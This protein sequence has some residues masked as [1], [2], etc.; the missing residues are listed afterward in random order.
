MSD[1][2]KQNI[3][4]LLAYVSQT[5]TALKSETLN[6]M[7]FFSVKIIIINW[8]NAYWW[9]IV[10]IVETNQFYKARIEWCNFFMKYIL[11]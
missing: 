4:K 10:L 1:I 8:T 3:D 2:R 11:L 7:E 6:S 9:N 5:V